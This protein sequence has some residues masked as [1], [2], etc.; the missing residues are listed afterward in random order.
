MVMRQRFNAGVM[1]KKVA[2]PKERR[3]GAE[4]PD[5]SPAAHLQADFTGLPQQQPRVAPHLIAGL[6]QL[7]CDPGI[8]GSHC[9][10][11]PAHKYTLSAFAGMAELIGVLCDNLGSNFALHVP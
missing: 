7:R 11:I 4:V 2:A 5:P 3:E 1:H 9:W 6:L 8:C 10:L